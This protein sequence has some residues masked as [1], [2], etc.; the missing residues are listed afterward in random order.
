MRMLRQIYNHITDLSNG[1][2]AHDY[3]GDICSC[4]ILNNIKSSHASVSSS[5]RWFDQLHI[6]HGASISLNIFKIFMSYYL[7]QLLRLS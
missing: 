4:V 1:F 3:D 2:S 5:L 6:P 7:C